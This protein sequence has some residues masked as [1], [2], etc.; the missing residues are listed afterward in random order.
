[1]LDIL[2][3]DESDF[4]RVNLTDVDT[5]E[6]I[7]L[8]VRNLDH[9]EHIHDLTDVMDSAAPSLVQ[10][11]RPEV[12][13]NTEYE[14]KHEQLNKFE[15]MKEDYQ[16]GFFILV[17]IISVFLFA[18]FIYKCVVPRNVILLCSTQ[19]RCIQCTCKVIYC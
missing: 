12:R 17:A 11:V 15:S 6:G 16:I 7:V 5:G 8:L 19:Y 2:L 14:P 9:E 13:N 18:L 3:I 4:G 10:E 1:M